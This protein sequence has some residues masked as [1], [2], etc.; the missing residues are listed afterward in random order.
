MTKFTCAFALALLVPPL[1]SANELT[2]IYQLAVDNDTQIRAA[3]GARDD[4]VAANPRARGALLPQIS[5]TAFLEEGTQTFTI[6]GVEQPKE[7]TDGNDIRLTLRQ[8]IFDASAWNRWQSAGQAA[9]AAQATYVIA[10]QNL[11][12]RVTE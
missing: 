12:F 5:G 1:A 6:N 7:D 9:A 3:Q 11:T 10:E 2:R 4:A 8:A